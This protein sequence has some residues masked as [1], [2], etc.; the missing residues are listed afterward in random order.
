MKS[1][2]RSRNKDVISLTAVQ[3]MTAGDL[4]EMSLQVL[5]NVTNADFRIVSL[6]SDN[7][8]INLNCFKL[9]SGSDDL[10]LF[11]PNPVNPDYRIYILFDTVHLIKFIRNNW[12]NLKNNQKTFYFPDAL[13]YVYI[14]LL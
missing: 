1:S 8:I 5:K 12:I 11:I 13:I 6:I 7:N 2:I 14:Y 10:R 3:N 4:H 9:L